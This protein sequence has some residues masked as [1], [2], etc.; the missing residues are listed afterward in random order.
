MIEETFILETLSKSYP[1]QGLSID[2]ITD[3][4]ET[5]DGT[6]AD[7]EDVHKMT[8][9]HPLALELLEIYGQTTH[10]DWLKFLDEEIINHMP[11]EEH[12]LLATLAVADSPVKW[13]K[14][15][16][17]VN[18]E[19]NPPERLLTYGLLI[20]LDEGMWLHEALRERFQREVGSASKSGKPV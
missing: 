4:V 8:G 5:M 12:E 10:G 19:G 17:A 1:L 3:W 2:E 16:S 7:P 9:G 15:S 14:L 13:S 6:P 20:E 11:A 18:W